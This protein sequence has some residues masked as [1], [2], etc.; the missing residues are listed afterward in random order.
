MVSNTNDTN[1]T[2]ETPTAMGR[3]L[4]VSPL[5]GEIIDRGPMPVTL[6]PVFDR[7]DWEPVAATL[8]VGEG[9]GKRDI[10]LNPSELLKLSERLNYL[11]ETILD[12]SFKR[13]EKAVE[14]KA[15]E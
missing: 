12:A 4:D 6:K 7:T 5:G 9:L 10:T 15:G 11:T 13:A 2:T 3:L 14:A 1:T 8:T